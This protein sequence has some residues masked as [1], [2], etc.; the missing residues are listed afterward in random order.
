MAF[1][2]RHGRMLWSDHEACR[3]PN[4][5]PLPV[6]PVAGRAVGLSRGAETGIPATARRRG[7]KPRTRAQQSPLVRGWAGSRRGQL[8]GAGG[9]TTDAD[10]TAYVRAI[11]ALLCLPAASVRSPPL[12]DG[13]PRPLKLDAAVA[14]WLTY[15]QQTCDA[16]T[17]QWDGGTLYRV[18]Y[19]KCLV[20]V[21]W[22]HMNELADLY[23]GLW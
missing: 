18:A 22:D 8:L 1:A 14:T 2:W 10:Y 6:S 21:T 19:P 17:F 11:G 16:M 7:V 23:A 13:P 20:T 4:R 12:P 15:R 9:K 3:V 5:L